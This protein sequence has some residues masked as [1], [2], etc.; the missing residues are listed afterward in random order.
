MEKKQGDAKKIADRVNTIFNLVSSAKNHILNGSV[1]EA[2][3][4]LVKALRLY[5]VT[6]VIKKERDLLED[7]FY[8]LEI[9]LSRHPKFIDTYGP[10]SFAR[11]EHKMAINFMSQ[12]FNLEPE[13]IE[14]KFSRFFV[15]LNQDRLTD[16]MVLTQ[17]I[18]EDPGVELK[19]MLKLGD[20]YLKRKHWREAENVYRLA[21]KKY[22]NSTHTLNRMA[23]SLRKKGQ[24]KEALAF[25]RDLIRLAPSDEGVYYNMARAYMEW[26]KQ[27]QALQAL[28][29]ALKINP[30]FEAATRILT[31]L[32]RNIDISASRDAKA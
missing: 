20:A 7:Q 30:N 13:P 26:G 23:I 11:G 27:E 4:T 16:A 8:E 21:N 29:Q 28:R 15:L 32:E 6:P 25:Y 10:V 2:M 18:L 24:Y 14:E 12:L 19:H 9:K 22:S 17:E 5:L 31:E 3:K 1:D